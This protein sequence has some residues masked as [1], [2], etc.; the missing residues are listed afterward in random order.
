MIKINRK[1]IIL[2]LIILIF[3]IGITSISAASFDDVQDKIDIATSGDEVYLENTTYEGSGME[4]TVNK[5]LTI[6]GGSAIDHNKKSTL[7]AKRLSRIFDVTGNHNVSF[8]NL[9][10]INGKANN[11]NGGSITI[12]N[13]NFILINCTF[14]NSSTTGDSYNGGAIYHNGAGSFSVVNSSFINSSTKGQNS[15]G[16]AIFN[17]GA[18]SFSVVNSSFMNSSTNGQSS[19]GGAII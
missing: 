6:H 18:G 3:Y 16:G 5:D 11:N 1:L 4:I 8:I 14:I 12:S 17:Y 10:L 2:A 7:D 13:S 15:T 19:H 9:I